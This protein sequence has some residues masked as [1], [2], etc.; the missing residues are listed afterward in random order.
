M[1]TLEEGL[2][3]YLSTSPRATAVRVST[4][5]YPLLIPQDVAL[6]AIAYQRV[7]GGDSMVAHDASVDFRRCT[8][9]FTCQSKTYAGAKAMVQALR[10]DLNGLRNSNAGGV[11]IQYANAGEEY[12]TDEMLD[13]AVSRVDVTFLYRA[14]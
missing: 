4:R 2:Y 11:D 3:A 5:I 10:S 14:P 12:D 1:P 13:A 8:I 9:Q 6:D 7:G